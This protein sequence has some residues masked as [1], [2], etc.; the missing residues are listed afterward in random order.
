VTRYQPGF[1][2]C[3][4][5]GL[6]EQHI[7]RASTGVMTELR[8]RL[9]PGFYRCGPRLQGYLGRVFRTPF[10]DPLSR[11][12][13]HRQKEGTQESFVNRASTGVTAMM[14]GFRPRLGWSLLIDPPA[15]PP[16]RTGSAQN[17]MLTGLLPV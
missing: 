11:V 8:W 13:Q 10:L 17:E 1:Y 12:H 9:Q 6:R 3:G 5:R 14:R 4:G 15:A 2:R 7:N 16:V